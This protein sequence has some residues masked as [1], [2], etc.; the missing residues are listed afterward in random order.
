MQIV[1]SASKFSS[2]YASGLVVVSSETK[3]FPVAIGELRGP[4]ARRMAAAYAVQHGVADAHVQQIGSPYSVN[5]EGKTQEEVLRAT[6]DLPPSHPSL[7]PAGYRIDVP[8][9][10]HGG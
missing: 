1:E 9:V 6:P 3:P 2:D 7:Q 10:R 4:D 5:A 8:V